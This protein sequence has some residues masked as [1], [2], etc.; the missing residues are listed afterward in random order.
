MTRRLQVAGL[1]QLGQESQSFHFLESVITRSM[2]LMDSDFGETLRT[3]L[4]S[5]Q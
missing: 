2:K 5:R 4:P 3:Q 1:V